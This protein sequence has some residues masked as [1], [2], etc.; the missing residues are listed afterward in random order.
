[1]TK[2]VV[3]LFP[4]NLDKVDSLARFALIVKLEL[5]DA[6]FKVHYTKGFRL[7]YPIP[8]PTT[9][10]G[11]FASMLGLTGKEA[12]TK[13]GNYR[14]GAALANRQA[15]SVE[16]ATYIQHKSNRFVRGVARMHILTD[17]AFYLVTT[18]ENEEKIENME[19]KINEGI[20]Y[21]PFG[22]QNDFFAKDWKVLKSESVTLSKEIGNYLPSNFVGELIEGVSMEILPVMHKLGPTQEFYFV[23]DGRLISKK[24]LPVCPVD[25]KNIA[26]YKLGDFYPVGEW[27][28]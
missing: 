14:F 16:Q 5:F 9:V 17:A 26:L 21:L 4:P 6:H 23:L 2:S 18:C 13:F 22:G 25:G 7:T 11:F 8:L 1:L 3:S 19:T 28:S 15:E 10:A 24:E 20:E 12:V 27:S